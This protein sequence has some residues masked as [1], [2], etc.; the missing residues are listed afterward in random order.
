MT[1]LRFRQASE[2]ERERL[3]KTLVAAKVFADAAEMR[4]AVNQAPWRL[5]VNGRGDVAVLGK[6]REHLS[7]LSVDAL[8][9]PASTVPLAMSCFKQLAMEQGLTDVVSPPV[10]VEEMDAYQRAGMRVQTTVMTLSRTSLPEDGE[11]V[12]GPGIREAG[13]RDIERLLDVDAACFEPFWRY[14][15]AH[16]A[17]FLLRGR[18]AI[19]ER[20]GEPVGY[21][22]CTV[23][24]DEGLLGRLCVKPAWRNQ[25]I[26]S[27]LLDDAL[28]SARLQGA[29]HMTLSTQVDNATS[30]SLYRQFG[31]R[32]NGRRYAFLRFAGDEG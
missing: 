26:G 3:T 5:Q 32:D 2:R 8:W 22:L 21:T 11:R 9:C 10:P 6:W 12:A 27:S 19:A 15:A 7:I 18:L 29:R 20:D 28:R 17:R 31:F 30:Q 24:G 13:Y 25:G 16:I 4:E 23:D 14:D 1:D